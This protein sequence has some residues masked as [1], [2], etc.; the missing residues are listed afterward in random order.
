MSS[1]R[2]PCVSLSFTVC[3]SPL[4]FAPLNLSDL[5]TITDPFWKSLWLLGLGSLLSE[6]WGLFP[7]SYAQGMPDKRTCLLQVDGCRNPC[8][9]VLC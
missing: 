7:A 8:F 3:F 5:C 6:A 2:V 4:F 9:S 1:S